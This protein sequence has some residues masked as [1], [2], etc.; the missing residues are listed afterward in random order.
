MKRDKKIII[1]SHCIINQNSVVLPLARAKGA[2]NKIIKVLIENNLGIYQMPCPEFIYGGL[3]RVPKTKDE[4]N[5]K[6]YI[7]LCEKLALGVVDDIMKYL[8]SCYTIKGLIGI[9]QSP[10][11]SIR[12]Q[13][14]IFM[15][16]LLE[17]FKMKSIKLPLVDISSSYKESEDN[18]GFLIELS[19]LIK[20]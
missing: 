10:T 6:P 20:D 15:E 8:E 16:I 17:M 19:N 13:Q 12:N 3:N 2:Y 9:N 5:E 18:T 11:C 7:E 14:G 1:L 4:Y